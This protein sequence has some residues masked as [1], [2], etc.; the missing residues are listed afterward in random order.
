M[1]ARLP[2]SHHSLFVHICQLSVD[3]GETGR[4][5]GNCR[6]ASGKGHK[7]KLLQPSLRPVCPRVCMKHFWRCI[8][9]VRQRHTRPPQ[10]GA[11]R[12][13]RGGPKR[14]RRWRRRGGRARRLLPA[15]ERNQAPQT[16]SPSPPPFRGL[17]GNGPIPNAVRLQDSSRRWGWTPCRALQPPFPYPEGKA[18][19]LAGASNG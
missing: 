6:G 16:H 11:C 14:R 10:R 9:S 13:S 15:A 18:Q 17:P 1:S 4:A 7:D 8:R 3:V 19:G 5:N 12:T 2:K